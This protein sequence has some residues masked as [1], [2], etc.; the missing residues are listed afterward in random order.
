MRPAAGQEW[1][2]G[3]A[4]KDAVP[5]WLQ[6]EYSKE[7]FPI[8]RPRDFGPVFQTPNHPRV[9][10]SW[11]EAGAY[12][13]WLNS[14]DVRPRLANDLGLTQGNDI[15]IRLPTESEWELA[16][17]WNR[18]KREADDRLF[19]WGDEKSEND[20][21]ERCNWHKCGI[22]STSAV[23]LFPKGNADCGAADLSGNVWEWCRLI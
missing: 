16:A 8:S 6:E 12:C 17:R 19:P 20:L 22:E 9:G 18:E 4:S 5:E 3:R 15:E 21:T 23:G 11:F 10:V 13:R 7:T 2:Q 1:R 14:S